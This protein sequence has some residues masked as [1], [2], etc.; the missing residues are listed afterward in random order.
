MKIGY[1]S[2]KMQYM[3]KYPA[4]GPNDRNSNPQSNQRMDERDDS[5]QTTDDSS[6]TTD[7][8][9]S[10]NQRIVC[11]EKEAEESKKNLE[12]RLH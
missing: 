4:L 8:V 6:Q 7:E 11:L 12:Q 5:A 3:Q 10:L 2:L 1:E 9:N